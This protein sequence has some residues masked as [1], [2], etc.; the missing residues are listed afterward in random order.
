M[1]TMCQPITF[2]RPT[3]SANACRVHNSLV[4]S[5]AHTEIVSCPPIGRRN[6]KKKPTTTSTKIKSRR[7]MYGREQ[8]EREIVQQKAKQKE[9][10]THQETSVADVASHNVRMTAIGVCLAGWASWQMRR[11]VR[12]ATSVSNSTSAGARQATPT[13][14]TWLRLMDRSSPPTRYLNECTT[15]KGEGPL[16]VGIN[17]HKAATSSSAGGRCESFL[18]EFRF[19]SRSLHL[20]WGRRNR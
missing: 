12:S 11:M 6:R 18:L 2:S 19:D 13:P 16:F 10:A 5:A 3:A 14:A 20:S 8:P 9:N 7:P 4:L 15:D 1:E 17:R